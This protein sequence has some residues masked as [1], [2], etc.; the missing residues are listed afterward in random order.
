MPVKSE[1]PR[2]SYPS[3]SGYVWK[4]LEH[5]SGVTIAHR[6]FCGCA[7]LNNPPRLCACCFPVRI[8][9]VPDTFSSLERSNSFPRARSYPR[10][11]L[12][13]VSQK[14]ERPDCASG[15]QRTQDTQRYAQTR[16]RTRPRSKTRHTLTRPR[17]LWMTPHLTKS[18]ASS[19]PEETHHG[20]TRPLCA[21]WIVIL[22]QT[23]NSSH[24]FRQPSN[25]QSTHFGNVA[26]LHL[27]KTDLLRAQKNTGLKVILPKDVTSR[28]L[29]PETLTDNGSRS[30]SHASI[31]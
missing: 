8:G 21:E 20:S 19:F 11:I 2:G 1:L 26:F 5:V 7:Q 27:L 6:S 24:R 14:K 29:P 9:S 13:R 28:T 25:V 10:H 18:S 31:F 4:W 12:F 15:G 17:S 16:D 30:F 3:P 22:V 23:T